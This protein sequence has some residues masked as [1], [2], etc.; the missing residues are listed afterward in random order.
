MSP[1]TAVITVPI[2]LAAIAAFHA[3][4]AAVVSLIF[5]ESTPKRSSFVEIAVLLTFVAA[6]LLFSAFAAF[7]D[8]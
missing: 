8:A 4:C 2:G 7:L 1:V 3:V 5:P 6:A